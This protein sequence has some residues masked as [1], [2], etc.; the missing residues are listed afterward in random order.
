MSSIRRRPS[1]TP[2]IRRKRFIGITTWVFRQ[3][4]KHPYIYRKDSL[5]S[6]RGLG[7]EPQPYIRRKDSL[8][9]VR[10]LGLELVLYIRQRI[11]SSPSGAP[12]PAGNQ[13][14]QRR[15]LL[16]PSP[17]AACSFLPQTPSHAEDQTYPDT[18]S[19]SVLL[20]NRRGSKLGDDALYDRR[21]SRGPRSRSRTTPSRQRHLILSAERAAF[22]RNRVSDTSY[23]RPGEP[24]YIAAASAAPFRTLGREGRLI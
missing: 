13:S 24:L 17:P 18:G 14:P 9:S 15:L 1:P 4:P 20:R 19:A 22:Y 12:A 11:L 10:R 3:E 6:V 21:P 8:V 7:L 5:V 16:P 23:S 2:N